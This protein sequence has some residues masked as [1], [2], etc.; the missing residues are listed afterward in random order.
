MS[1]IEVGFC[2][3]GCGQRTPIATRTNLSKGPYAH[4]PCAACRQ[5]LYSRST[6]SEERQKGLHGGWPML[7]PE[8]LEALVAFVAEHQRCGELDGGR[9]GD[10]IWLACSCGARIVHPV[11]APPPEPART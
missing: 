7:R 2:L 9:D 10:Y 5:S 8:P 3:C 6:P 11:S 1:D 4:R